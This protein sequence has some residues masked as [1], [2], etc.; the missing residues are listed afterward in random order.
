MTEERI[1]SDLKIDVP[2]RL[3]VINEDTQD[4][5]FITCEGKKEG[6]ELQVWIALH[7]FKIHVVEQATD[8]R[9]GIGLVLPAEAALA[10]SIAIRALFRNPGQQML[11]VHIPVPKPTKDADPVDDA[12]APRPAPD[13]PVRRL[14]RRR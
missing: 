13:E 1:D 3:S 7:G 2:V 4:K 5:T 8:G 12:R 10:L 9:P 14:R 11:N 6:G